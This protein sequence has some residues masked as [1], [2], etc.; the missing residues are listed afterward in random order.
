MMMLK[1][2]EKL[3]LHVKVGRPDFGVARDCACI[4]RGGATF[5]NPISNLLQKL[6]IDDQ[7]QLLVMTY[8]HLVSVSLVRVPLLPTPSSFLTWCF[9]FLPAFLCSES[10]SRAPGR[11]VQWKCRAMFCRSLQ[12]ALHPRDFICTYLLILNHFTLIHC[13]RVIVEF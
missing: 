3:T 8:F 1:R 2:V 5:P 10:P 13:R 12:Q 7:Q 6:P 4:S 9:Q 11:I